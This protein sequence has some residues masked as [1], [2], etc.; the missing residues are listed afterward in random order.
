[1]NVAAGKRLAQFSGL[2]GLDLAV[3]AASTAGLAI[4][5]KPKAP[6]IGHST[7]ILLRLRPA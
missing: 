2:T 5:E 7:E 3:F 1:M 6:A 4:G